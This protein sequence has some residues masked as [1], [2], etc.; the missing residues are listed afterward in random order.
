MNPNVGTM[1]VIDYAHGLLRT[2]ADVD[3][4]T[5]GGARVEF[6]VLS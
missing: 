2:F 1:A 6:G 4:Q 3:G 5:Y